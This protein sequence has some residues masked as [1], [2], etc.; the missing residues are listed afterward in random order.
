MKQRNNQGFIRSAR[1]GFTLIEMLVVVAIVGI[2]SATVLSALGPSRNKARDARIISGLNQVRAIA[3]TLY[4]PASAS[5]YSAV[6][7][8]ESTIAKV[9][10]D[11]DSQGGELK[12]VPASPGTAYVAYSKLNGGSFYCVDSAGTAK[13][14][15]EPGPTATTCP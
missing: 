7:A 5:P 13:T 14:T 8:T 1:S 15:T 9:K 3:E 12:I 6:I 2:L 4:N 10:T 11:V